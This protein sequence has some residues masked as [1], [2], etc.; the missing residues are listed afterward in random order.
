MN[1]QKTNESGD[2]AQQSSMPDVEVEE[3]NLRQLAISELGLTI[4]HSDDLPMAS[5]DIETTDM[6]TQY[7]NLRSDLLMGDTCV[8]DNGS[9]A[10]IIKN[11]SDVENQT[12]F[13]DEITV[14]EDVYGLMLSGT[15]CTGDMDLLDRF[16]NSLKAIFKDA[17][18]IE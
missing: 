13:V 14:G 2:T 18:P 6:G 17:S 1:T 5:Y 11:P 15:N 8:E 3:T 10:Q 4:Q 9:I 16:Q 7:A 12:G